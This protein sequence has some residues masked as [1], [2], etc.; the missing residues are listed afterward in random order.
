MPNDRSLTLLLAG[1][2]DAVAAW[3]SAFQK[4]PFRLLPDVTQKADLPA[5]LAA[6][7]EALL[8]DGRL[9][10]GVRDLISH[11]TLAQAAAY[12][13]VPDQATEVERNAIAAVMCVKGTYRP[14]LNLA[15]LAKR[16]VRDLRAE[17]SESAVEERTPAARHGS[18]VA[19][20]DQNSDLTMRTPVTTSRASTIRV[21]VR[22]GFYGTRGGAGASTAALR[23]AQA[24]ADAGLRVALFDA[25][26]R[27]DLHLMLGLQPQEQPVQRAGITL[28]LA[29]PSEDVARTFDA[30]VIDGGRTRGTFNA[31]WIQVAGPLGGDDIRRL[32]GLE[33]IQEPHRPAL[34]LRVL[35][36]WLP[37]K[38]TSS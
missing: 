1:P 6:Q 23:V 16:M 29:A 33:P 2:P 37:A 14:N 26:R 31:D 28:F 15:R 17:A 19:T 7:P 22:L 30:V 36:R 21:R 35:S 9:F 38:E 11:L 3:R 34:P 20:S 8:I 25:I 4:E 32:A 24:L 5:A 13:V 18:P 27:G 12:V 10:A